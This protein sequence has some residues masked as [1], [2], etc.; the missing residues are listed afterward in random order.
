MSCNL[1]VLKSVVVVREHRLGP[2]AITD[3]L[4]RNTNI[5]GGEIRF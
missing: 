2:A 5:Q 3:M 4:L 1:A